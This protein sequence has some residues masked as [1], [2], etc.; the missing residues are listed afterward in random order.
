[1]RVDDW[2]VLIELVVDLETL[3]VLVDCEFWA[4]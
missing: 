1:M 4:L 2:V 3:D